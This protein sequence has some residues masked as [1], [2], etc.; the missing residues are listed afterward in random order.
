MPNRRQFIAMAGTATAAFAA[1]SRAQQPKRR[2][3]AGR[4]RI[5]DGTELFIKDWGRGR[6]VV[7]THA[8]PLS[9]DCWDAQAIAL[10]DAGFRVIMYDRRGFGRSSQPPGGYDYNTYADDLAAVIKETG[11]RDVSLVG[12]SM[13]GGEIVR[14]LSRHGSKHVIKAGLVATV[15]PGLAKNANNPNGVD[16]SFFDTLKDGLRGNR[17]EFYSSLLKDVFYDVQQSAKSTHPVSQ[18]ILDWSMQMAMQAGLLALIES[19]DAFGK[20]DFVPDLA[21]VT[22]PTLILHGSADKP[23]PLDL[24]ARRAA[25]G[26]KQSKLI[27]YPGVTHGLLVTERERVG[28]DLV[29]FLKA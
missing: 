2:Q 21:A 23:V 17:A 8:W 12:F 6:P 27:E 29:E 26:I 5:K 3:H 25:A 15:V 18:A 16:P 20:E 22:M 28:N 7:L 9:S 10:V 24:T 1:P 19:V 11:V 13:G 4:V 14:Y